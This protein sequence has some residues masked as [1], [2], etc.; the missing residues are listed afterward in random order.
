MKRDVDCLELDYKVQFLQS[1]IKI[2]KGCG[3]CPSFYDKE[4]KMVESNEMRC[5]LFGVRL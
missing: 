5:W 3:M 4:V 2:V 1:Y